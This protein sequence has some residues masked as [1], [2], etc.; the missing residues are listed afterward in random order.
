L[1]SLRHR[2][3]SRVAEALFI[4]P[5]A[6]SV[7]I[8]ELE[9]QL[10]F[11]LFDRTTRHVAL[12]PHGQQFPSV[13]QTGLEQFDTSVSRIGRS[14]VEAR[15]S[16]SL[17]AT[18]L[19]A[20]NILPQGIKEFRGHCPDLRIRLFEGDH[21]TILRRIQAGKLDM[22]L[23]IFFETTTGIRR[24]P[25]FRFSLMVSTMACSACANEPLPE[26]TCF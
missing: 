1:F 8:W 4:T 3:F 23:G 7:S 17:G 14:V 20:A 9:S 22:A 2:N 18:P 25:F 5:S 12:A 16:L 10:G 15:R 19:V 11:R 24:T 26:S 21:P 13:A 6:L